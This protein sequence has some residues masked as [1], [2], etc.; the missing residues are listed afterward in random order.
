MPKAM[1]FLTG[2][3]LLMMGI[4]S[5]AKAQT[6]AGRVLD[7]QSKA[8]LRQIAVL[9]VADTGAASHVVANAT[10]DSLGTF[11]LDAPSAGVYRLQFTTAND[12]LITGSLSLAQD[13][14]AQHEYLLQTHAPERA[15]FV[16]E[17]MRQVQ[18]SPNNR[19]PRYPDALRSANIQGEVL[20]QFV[21][22]T[23]GRAEM[24]TFKVLRSTDMLFTSA[25]RRAVPDFEFEP[26]MIANGKVRQLVQMPFYFCLNGGP[27]LTARPD[28]GRFWAVPPVRAGVCPLR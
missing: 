8:P 18:P 5:S 14:V 6:V 24:N 2:M 25:V 27:N 3:L 26:A 16:F 23:T 7:R 19:P 21:V 22:D 20:V 11:Y 10:T 15:Y 12:T 1:R 17:V 9:L 4:V 28:T 13:E